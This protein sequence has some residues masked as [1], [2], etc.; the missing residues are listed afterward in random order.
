MRA[1]FCTGVTC[2]LALLL[3]ACAG[4]HLQ[5]RRLD[6]PTAT[7]SKVVVASP[8][9]HA[10]LRAAAVRVERNDDNFLEIEVHIMNDSA[11]PVPVRFRV[12]FR[13][14]LNKEVGRDDA[15][16]VVIAP[17]QTHILTATSRVPQAQDFIVEV[18]AAKQ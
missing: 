13:D 8:Q 12:I 3:A 4:P 1:F 15:Q 2:L 11:T 10:A 6:D 17:G 16:P 9:L 5:A 18:R 14:Y 7:T